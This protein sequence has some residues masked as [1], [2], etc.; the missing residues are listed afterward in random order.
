[1]ATGIRATGIIRR[2]LALVVIAA[3]PLPALGQAAAPEPR[4]EVRRF[5]V[6]GAILL[7]QPEVDAVLA[8][9]RGAQRGFADLQSARDAL[10]GAYAARGFRAVEVTLPAQDITSGVV[11]LRVLERKVARV[12][13]EGNR[14]FGTA[15]VRASVPALRE[16]EAPNVDAINL[17]LRI[18]NES[19]AKRSVVVF[20]PGANEAELEAVVR[21]AEEDPLSAF[22]SLDNSGTKAT[23]T[24]RA[25]AGFRHANLFDRDHVLNMQYVTAPHVPGHPNSM[26]LLPSKDVTILGAGYHLPAYAL[27]GSFDFTL[28]Y[29]NVNSGTLANLFSVSGSGS[30]YAA[31]FNRP[32]GRIGEYEHRVSAGIDWRATRNAVTPIGGG[33]SLVPDITVHP[34]SLVYSGL[35]PGEG[36]ETAFNLGVWQNLPG[37]DNGD[38]PAFDRVRAGASATYQLWRYA[39]THTSTVATD[40][41]VRVAA[42]GQWTRDLLVPG[43]QFGAG[44]ADSVRGFL[45]RELGNDR[46]HRA[47]VEVYSP[48]FGASLPVAG[49]KLRLLAF[50]DWARL[51]RNRPTVLEAQRQGL[52]SAG[53][54]MRLGIGKSFSARADFG[55]VTHAGGTQGRGDGRMH[56]SLAWLF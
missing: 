56:A 26:S 1:M 28:G 35:L 55:V 45:E 36:R 20:N 10:V 25:G 19:P 23:G 33:A 52:A 40:M 3:A 51:E 34:L 43:E 53:L 47:S 30:I 11:R 17:D 38:Q 8:P 24:F 31:R 54:G 39:F 37:G 14:H 21:V 49:A 48:D 41:Q 15:N 9:F 13:L 42:S 4:F 22:V 50:M 6:E 12:T 27:G 5:E 2:T 18:A 44:G 46:G 32:L 29:S 7:P 16:G